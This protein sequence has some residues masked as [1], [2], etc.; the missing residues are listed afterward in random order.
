MLLRKESK[1][2]LT[3]GLSILLGAMIAL[4]ISEII[5]ARR[6]AKQEKELKALLHGLRPVE[7]PPVPSSEQIAEAMSSVEG[8]IALTERMK[9]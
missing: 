9:K 1:M 6:L 5:E 2:K 3:T 8:I 4:P 7:M